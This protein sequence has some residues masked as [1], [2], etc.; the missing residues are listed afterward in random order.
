MVKLCVGLVLATAVW[1]QSPKFDVASV[2]PSQS[3]AKLSIRRDPAGGITFANATL[4]TLVMMAYNIQAYQLEG[5]Q[6][7]M[8]SE[9]YDV[10][11]KAP[12]EALKRD[13]W[14]MLQS[15]LADRFQLVVRRETKEMP[16]YEL[17]AA[18][19][20][21][22]FQEPSRPPGEADDS[23]RV[24]KGEIKLIRAGMNTLAF[25]LAESLDRRVVDK[26]GINGKFDLTL[27]WAPEGPTIF[28]ALTE[29]L[30]LRLESSKG[31]VSMVTVEHA[32]RPAAN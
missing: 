13:T 7:W 22:K 17:M 3:D 27:N 14:T 18:K 12:P 9:R 29:Q 32:E 8:Q 30:G 1:P 21:P 6:G 31:E 10:I 15:L 4:K 23:F 2:R 11:A 19:S 26:T 16:I 5:L 20:G 24:S 25:A 28:T